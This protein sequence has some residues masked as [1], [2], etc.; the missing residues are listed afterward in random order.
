MTGQ[1]RQQ[2]AQASQRLSSTDKLPSGQ[3]VTRPSPM[4]PYGDIGSVSSYGDIGLVLFSEDLHVFL[5]YSQVSSCQ[6]DD[7]VEKTV[8]HVLGIAEGVLRDGCRD[9]R[10]TDRDRH[11]D[12]GGGHFTSPLSQSPSRENWTARLKGER[13]FAA[14]NTSTARLV[15]EPT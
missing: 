3:S 6:F 7:V 10:F 11:L 2:H 15:A 1:S 5:R 4:T 13:A 14:L 9:G 8:R 12:P